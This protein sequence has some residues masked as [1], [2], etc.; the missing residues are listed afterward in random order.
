MTILHHD[1]RQF[2]EQ[3]T[4]L[5][6]IG[7]LRIPRAGLKGLLGMLDKADRIVGRAR[8]TGRATYLV[9]DRTTDLTAIA[10]PAI[11]VVAEEDY[12]DPAFAEKLRSTASYFL[13]V[14]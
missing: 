1:I 12:D 14:A 3:M 4:T 13:R 8:T 6:A 9:V 5:G 7:C 2:I 10:P 11:L